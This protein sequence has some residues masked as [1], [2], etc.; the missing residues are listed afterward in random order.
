MLTYRRLRV[1]AELPHFASSVRF[2]LK[3]KIGE[4]G[5]GIVYEALDRE[6][7]IPVALKT[8]SRVSPASLYLFKQEFRLI[9]NISH[10][11]LIPLYELFADSDLWYFTMELIDGV[12]LLE[13]VRAGC[14]PP[15]FSAA[16]TA[17]LDTNFSTTV[18]TSTADK[19]PTIRSP[20]FFE[21]VVL[22]D[23]ASREPLQKGTSP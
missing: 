10:P 1:A 18:L 17:S 5:M 9:A 11:N 15:R 21:E 4:G 8:L 13:F 12:N 2:E 7:K 3:R 19:L 20:A 14:I 16:P 23:I 22:D 6:R